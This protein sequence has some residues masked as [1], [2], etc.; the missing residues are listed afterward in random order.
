MLFRSDEAS[1]KVIVANPNQNNPLTARLVS[2]DGLAVVAEST[3]FVGEYIFQYLEGG[4]YQLQTSY[5]GTDVTSVAVDLTS[6]GLGSAMAIASATEVSIA[7]AIIE[8]IGQADG[9]SQYSWDFGDGTIVTDVANPVHAYAAPGVYTVTFTA[10]AGGCSSSDSFTITVTEDATGMQSLNNNKAGMVVFP[11]PAAAQTTLILN[12]GTQDSDDIVIRITDAAG[13][14]V[15]SQE[16]KKVR[17]GLVIPIELESFAN[18]IYQV[19]AE[20]KN[21]SKTSKLIVSK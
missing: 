21:F 3:P 6:D 16:M 4:N 2:N 17:S 1:G 13:R 8:F 12:L 7:D 11:N 18:G 15:W 19:S 14:V 9:A 10:V 5:E 20:G